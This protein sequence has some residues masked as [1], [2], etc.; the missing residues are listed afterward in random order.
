MNV[1]L[2]TLRI[3]LRAVWWAGAGLFNDS[4]E[5]PTQEQIDAQISGIAEEFFGI[6]LPKD[7]SELN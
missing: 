7:D 3:T 4:T 5:P 1:D 2:Q 6:H